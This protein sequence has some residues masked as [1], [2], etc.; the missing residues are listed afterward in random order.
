LALAAK[1]SVERW[2]IVN[3]EDAQPSAQA[4]ER[5]EIPV[6]ATADARLMAEEDVGSTGVVRAEALFASSLQSSESP[7][8]DQVRRAVGSTLRQ[9]G[10]NGCVALLAEEFGQHPD[11]AAAR[12]TWALRTA[13][14][15]FTAS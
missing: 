7:T 5:G 13:E 8:A 15:A 14:L 12:M 4:K 3:D 9:L 2:F 1:T 6:D 10:A 11:D